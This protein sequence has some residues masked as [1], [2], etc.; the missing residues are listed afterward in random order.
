MSLKTKSKRRVGRPRVH[1]V[2]REANLWVGTGPTAIALL[3]RFKW[4]RKRK[5]Y[6]HSKDF[7]RDMLD[8]ELGYVFS[9]LFQLP[10]IVTFRSVE[11]HRVAVV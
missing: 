1:A 9:R 3:E 2:G 5:G 10:C 7:L 8:R 4:G 11:T 6:E